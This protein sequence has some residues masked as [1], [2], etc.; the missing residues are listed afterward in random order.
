MST[1]T[2]NI[3]V[4]IA[5]TLTDP[6]SIVLSDPTG[7]YGVKRNDTDATVVSDATAMTKVSTGVYYHSFTDPALDLTYGYWIETVYDGS[8][9]FSEATIDG[10][11]TD[12]P[13]ALEIGYTDLLHIVGDFTALGRNPSGIDLTRVQEVL[14]AGYRWM[15]HPPGLPGKRP[16]IWNFL[17]KTATIT[18]RVYKESLAAAT[19]TLSTKTLTDSTALFQSYGVEAGDVIQM[20][21]GASG[22]YEE[23]EVA[24]VTS[25]T[26]L[27]VTTAP[28][29]GNGSYAYYIDEAAWQY[30]L[31][32]DFGSIAS[33]FTSA[34]S[35]SGRQIMQIGVSD[36]LAMRQ[37]VETSGDPGFVAIRP[38]AFVTTTGQRYEALFYPTP[39]SADVLT[40]RYNVEASPLRSSTPYPLGGEAY[41]Q[42]LIEACLGEA[43]LRMEDGKSSIHQQARLAAL[44]SAIEADIL[45]GPRFLGYNSDPGIHVDRDPRPAVTQAIGYL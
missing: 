5:G 3:E 8:T 26:V 34:P 27:V 19:A 17:S 31:P 4:R 30:P 14:D 28:D 2:I 35:E 23:E 24:S 39:A 32:S 7:T 1:T 10:T 21:K 42:L 25:E 41:A 12:A 38:K 45:N 33:D 29:G 22:T 15:L 40:Y 36:L 11:R 9:Y 16:H 18:L 43:E 37:Y 6:T 20:D 13:S 44:A